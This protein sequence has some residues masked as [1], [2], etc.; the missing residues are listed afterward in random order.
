MYPRWPWNWFFAPLREVFLEIVAQPFVWLLGAPRVTLPQGP[1]PDGPVIVIAN[2]VTAYDAAI[3]LYALPRKLRRRAAIAMVGEMLL[4]LKRGRSQG[5]WFLNFLAL[6][7]YWLVTA[8]YN[9]FPMPR[10]HGFRKSIQHA[11]E[12]LP[13]G[14]HARVQRRWPNSLHVTVV[15]QPAAVGV[16]GGDLR[17][18]DERPVTVISFEGETF[19]GAAGARTERPSL[20][21]ALRARRWVRCAFW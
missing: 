20:S 7:Q 1:L 21:T 4:D 2:H 17:L 5:N 18:R 9:V 12:A 19:D 15:E 3:V 6:P 14:D 16:R 8:L 13:W 11:G 10:A